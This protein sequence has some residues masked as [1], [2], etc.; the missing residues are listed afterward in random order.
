MLHRS[1]AVASVALAA[2]CVG[3]TAAPSDPRIFLTPDVA[4]LADPPV[5]SLGPPLRASIRLVNP[6]SADRPV[7]QTTDWVNAAGMPLRTLLSTP[8]RL[9]VPGYGDTT[10]RLIAPSPLAVQFHTRVE[11]DRS[12]TDTN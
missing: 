12:A 8:Q 9:T 11:P 2:G 5:V 6:S 10:I 7:L 3:P 1:I 4:V